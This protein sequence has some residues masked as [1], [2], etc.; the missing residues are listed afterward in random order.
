M[1]E[2]VQK[3]LEA[4]NGVVIGKEQTVKYSIICLLAGGHVLLEDVPGVGKTTLSRALAEASGCAFN[5][6]QFTP[7]TIGWKGM[8][9]YT[10]LLSGKCGR[11]KCNEKATEL[12][13]SCPP[14]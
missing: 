1:G 13:N 5:R 3:I 14:L 8:Y 10:D 11:K 12:W 7:D 2:K 9:F 4:V 6:I